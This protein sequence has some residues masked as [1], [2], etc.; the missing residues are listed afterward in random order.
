MNCINKY[1]H[2]PTI[3]VYYLYPS[4]RRLF[5]TEKRQSVTRALYPQFCVTLVI[6]ISSH[7]CVV[8]NDIL[9]N[10]AMTSQQLVLFSHRQSNYIKKLP[11]DKTFCY[12]QAHLTICKEEGGLSSRLIGMCSSTIPLIQR[13]FLFCTCMLYFAK[14]NATK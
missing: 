4:W 10:K 14:R 2:Q 11:A 12:L 5:L 6:D 13:V 8:C 9:C 3:Y 1:E 7:C